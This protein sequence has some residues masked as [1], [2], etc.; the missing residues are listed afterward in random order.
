MATIRRFGLSIVFG[1]IAVVSGIGSASA[2][3]DG[4]DLALEEIIV[5][6]QR[7]EQALKEVPISI[8]AFS[9]DLIRRQGFRDLGE[10]GNFSPSVF[11]N[12]S[13][14][15]SQDRSIRGFGTSGNALTLEQAV[16][17]F[18]DGIHFGR[19]SQVKLAFMDTARVE[20]L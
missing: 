12:D 4:A 17:I 6:A 2:Q 13:G 14:F 9:G 19:P 7:R 10:L 15:L 18:V 16:P 3:L 5:T 11:I 1:L 20:I 8:E